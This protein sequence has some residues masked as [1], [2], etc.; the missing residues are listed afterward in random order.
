MSKKEIIKL[1]VWRKPFYKRI[2]CKHNY[3]RYCASG[4]FYNGEYHY[5]ICNKCGKVKGKSEFVKALF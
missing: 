5:K 1:I 2:L 3:K 4:L